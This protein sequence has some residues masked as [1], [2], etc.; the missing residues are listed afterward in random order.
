VTWRSTRRS[1]ASQISAPPIQHFHDLRDIKLSR[2]G[3]LMH[4]QEGR[5]ELHRVSPEFPTL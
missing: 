4:R 5:A 3:H 2:G 1:S